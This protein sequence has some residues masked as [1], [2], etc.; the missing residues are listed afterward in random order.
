MTWQQAL[1]RSE[2]HAMLGYMQEHG[3]GVACSWSEDNELWECSWISSG[4][5]FSGLS[6]DLSVAART[7]LRKALEARQAR[8]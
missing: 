5:R 3:S 6:H 2:L 8:R 1:L 4:M 7:A